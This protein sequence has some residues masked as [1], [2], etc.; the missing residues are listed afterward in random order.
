MSN[1]VTVEA[2]NVLAASVAGTSY[3]APTTPMKLALITTTTPSTASAIGSEVTG[4]SYARQSLA[5]AWGSASAG[6]ITNSAASVS[7]TG[8][9]SCTIGG[10]EIWDSSTRTVTDGV[11]NSTTTI[12]SATASFVAADVGKM[13]TDATNADIPAGTYIA[14]VTNSTTAVMSASA[15]G[16]HTLQ[17]LTFGP[18]RNW[19]GVLTANKVVNTGDTVTFNTSSITITLS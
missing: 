16:G 19:F 11:T 13:V 14:S 6:S 10:I 1:I 17:S 15:T 3:N 18:K 12:T 4:G 2:N 9:P 8:M 5:S 7:F